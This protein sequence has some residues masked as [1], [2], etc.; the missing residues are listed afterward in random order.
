M[1][2]AHIALWTRD[3]D[4]A[5]TFWRAFFDAEV[6][7]RYA[8]CNREGFVSRFVTLPE[9]GLQIELMQGPW[10]G[11]PTPETVGW[12]HLALSAG[13]RDAVDAAAERFDRAGLLVSRPRLT[14]DGYY[15][16]VVQTPDGT[17][18]EIVA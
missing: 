2:L 18:I 12:A 15:E 6:G 3:V 5:A 9:S 11:E 10:V 14:G 16:A 8:S 13:S 7:D 17:L 1:K 4:G